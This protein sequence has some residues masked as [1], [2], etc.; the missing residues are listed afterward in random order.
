MNRSNSRKQKFGTALLLS[1]C[2]ICFLPARADVKLY[3]Y[4]ITVEL[5]ET[6]ELEYENSSLAPVTEARISYAAA[7]GSDDTNYETI[8]YGNGKAYGLMRDGDFEIGEGQGVVVRITH[9][10]NTTPTQADFDCSANAILRMLLDVKL[11]RNIFLYVTVP[12]DSFSGIVTAMCNEH[13]AVFT[14]K[15]EVPYKTTAMILIKDQSGQH[16]TNVCYAP[17]ST[18]PL[19]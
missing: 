13:F 12:D 19:R 1:F 8:T 18:G 14:P 4:E 17:T 9:D 7:D 11:S 15:L 16:R 3:D 2:C 10:A 6:R 5:V